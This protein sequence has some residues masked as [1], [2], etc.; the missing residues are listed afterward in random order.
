M[1][2]DRLVANS[3]VVGM[4]EWRGSGRREEVLSVFREVGGVREQC[5][6]RRV[7]EMQ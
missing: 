7:M 4:V 5:G 1:S 3:A 6:K 2:R